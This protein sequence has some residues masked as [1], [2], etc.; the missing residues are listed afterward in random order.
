[1]THALRIDAHRRCRGG[2]RQCRAQ[3][4][5][6]A[7][8]A[9]DGRHPHAAGAEPAAAGVADAA[10]RRACTGAQ[11][12]QRPPRRADQRDAQGVRR[13]EPQDRS[14][15]QRPARRARGLSDT[16]VQI[17]QLSQEVEALRLSIPQYPA[18][19]GACRPPIR[20]RRRSVGRR[21]PPGA[22]P[23]PH[24]RAPPPI[25]AGRA[26]RRSACTTRRG[27]ITPPASGTC[28]SAGFD[29]VPAHVPAQRAGRPG[30]V[31]HRRVQLPG[32]QASGSRAGVHQVIANYPEG[33]VGCA[34]VLQARAGVRASWASSIARAS[35]SSR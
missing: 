12:A 24:R 32:R 27:P 29:T 10:Q 1:M 6:Q 30:A 8:D 25:A 19:D 18:A 9:D 23:P 21:Q 5:E 15:R 28:A 17:G 16:N 34:G 14:V 11:G 3:R 33:P 31:L 20:V 7:R 4:A 13:S 35:R 26:C 22:T 2:R